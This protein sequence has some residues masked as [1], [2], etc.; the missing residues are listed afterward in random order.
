MSRFENLFERYRD[1]ERKEAKHKTWAAFWWVGL[2]LV[3]I[4]FYFLKD[5]K[6]AEAGYTWVA[7]VALIVAVIGEAVFFGLIVRAASRVSDEMGECKLSLKRLYVMDAADKCFSKYRYEPERGLTE[8]SLAPDN[9]INLFFSGSDDYLEGVCPNGIRFRRADIHS[10]E[11]HAS[12]IIYDSPKS[13]NEPLLI[14]PRSVI[15][16]QSYPEIETE[17][18]EFNRLFRCFSNDKADAFYV[19]TPRVMRALIELHKDLKRLESTSVEI[20]F[21]KDKVHV[22]LRR[23]TDP[24]EIDFSEYTTREVEAAYALI[25]FSYVRMIGEALGVQDDVKELAPSRAE[26]LKKEREQ[27]APKERWWNSPEYDASA[28]NK[29]ASEE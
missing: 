12:W 11:K 23:T 16:L 18:R 13:L 15:S 4:P 3:F 22:V 8:E 24:F 26:Q 7:A 9:M 2:V 19:L 21:V 10:G 14:R 1:L 29:P 5:E 17:D 27:R 25:E 20:T 28:E 6:T